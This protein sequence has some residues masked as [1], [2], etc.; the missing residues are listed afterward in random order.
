VQWGVTSSDRRSIPPVGAKLGR[1]WLVTVRYWLQDTPV[2][3]DVLVPKEGKPTKGCV[4]LPA[5]SLT[6]G[7]KESNQSPS[8]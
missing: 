4:L 6:G 3:G 8:N 2:M 5:P 1:Y 7:K